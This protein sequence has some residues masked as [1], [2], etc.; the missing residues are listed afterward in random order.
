MIRVIEF[1]TEYRS[2]G[3]E[4]VDWVLVAPIGA[5]FE[6]TQTWHRVTKLMPPAHAD[7]T[8]RS[9]ATFQ[10]MEAKWG[11]VGPAYSAWK[12][13]QDLPESGTPLEA[14]SGVTPEQVKFLKAL[15]I[16]TVEDVRGMGDATIEKLRFPSARKLPSLA[17]MWLEGEAIAQKD[18]RIVELEDRMAVMAEMLEE[19][20]T[21]QAEAQ[22]RGPGRPRKS[23]VEAS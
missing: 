21:A 5:D 11:I 23:E 3:Q 22:K 18:A 19:R 8:I 17:K 13:G 14:W 20:A 9:S 1:K 15:D 6:K 7:D 2:A 10:D 16:R 4:P 12:D